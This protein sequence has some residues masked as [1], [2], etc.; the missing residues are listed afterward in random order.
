MKL[1]YTVLWVE[2]NQNYVDQLEP[3]IR[4]LLSDK[5]YDLIC[6][7]ATGWDG[8]EEL[9]DEL[10]NSFDLMIID[11]KLD[12]DSHTGDV[13]IHKI[14]SLE[15]YVSIIFYSVSGAAVLR[16]KIAERELDGV[17]C[18]T[19]P[20]N[21]FMKSV[22][23]IVNASLKKVEE[24]N[25]LRG[26]ML[27]HTSDIESKLKSILSCYFYSAS[28]EWQGKIIKKTISMCEKDI[29]KTQEILELLQN[30]S[31][32]FSQFVSKCRFF[33]MEKKKNLLMHVLKRDIEIRDK[34]IPNREVLSSF[35]DEITVVRN[36]LAHVV[37]TNNENGNNL[38]DTLG[39]LEDFSRIRKDIRKHSE[40]LEDIYDYIKAF[41]DE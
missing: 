20:E 9:G 22:T 7:K 19:R 40:N 26:L 38:A 30:G 4:A 28:K 1:E 16:R 36:D 25:N 31:V 29:G 23:Q 32:D 24:T 14:R 6:E 27:A 35:K 2:D 11:Y 3:K 10:I 33:D 18:T 8:V 5:G 41:Q 17:F 39:N 12:D 37:E 21:E 13:V 15:C 34:L